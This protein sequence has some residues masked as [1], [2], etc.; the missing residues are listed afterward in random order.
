MKKDTSL[1]SV[2]A[3]FQKAKKWKPE[4]ELLREIV[5]ETPLTEELKWYQPCYTYDGNNVV[6]IGGFKEYCVLSFFKGALLKDEKSILIQPTENMQAV[7][8]LR[9]TNTDEIKKQKTLIKKYLKDAIEIEKQGLKVDMKKSREFDLPEEL[10]AQFAN[11]PAL[12]K[13]FKA[14]TTGR[15]RAY[16]LF[17]SAAKQ[18]LTRIARIEKNI[19]RILEGKGLND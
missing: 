1:P 5:L 17:F 19:S 11:N 12:E 7:R 15:Q 14:L 16:S 6:I 2:D 4:I 10:L 18:S 13:A 8:Q 9:F 3:F